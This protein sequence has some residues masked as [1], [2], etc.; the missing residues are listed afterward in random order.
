MIQKIEEAR[1]ESMRMIKEADKKIEKAERKAFLADRKIAEAD[2]KIEELTRSVDHLLE[3][4]GS[5]FLSIFGS[6]PRP[7]SEKLFRLP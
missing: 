6:R 7:K 3:N 2:R 1:E 5:G 4:R